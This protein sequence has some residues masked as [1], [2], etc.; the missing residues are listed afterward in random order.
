M[1]IPRTRK[2]GDLPSLLAD[3]FLNATA[4]RHNNGGTGSVPGCSIGG[5]HSEDAGMASGT[6]QPR[7]QEATKI[8]PFGGDLSRSEGGNEKPRMMCRKR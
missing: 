1:G 4:S 3:Q 6:G 7:H 5:Q 2:S 8:G